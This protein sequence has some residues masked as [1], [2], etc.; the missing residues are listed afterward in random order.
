MDMN[1]EKIH[2]IL[3]EIDNWENVPINRV[4]NNQRFYNNSTELT[5]RIIMFGATQTG[6]TTVIL[7]LMGVKDNRQNEL[8]EI[9]RGGIAYGKSSTSTTVIYSRSRN[10]KFAIAYGDSKNLEIDDSTYQEFD[11]KEFKDKIG[12]Q[13]EANRKNVR[14]DASA[15]RTTYIFIPDEFFKENSSPNLQIVDSRG[16]GERNVRIDDKNYVSSGEINGFVDALM[17]FASG[18]VAVVTVDKIK[19]LSSEYNEILRKKAKGQVL[20][21]VTHSIDRNHSIISETK[22][23][24]MRVMADAIK[25]QYNSIIIDNGY[26][27]SKFSDRIYPIEVKDFMLNDMRFKEYADL[28][29]YMTQ[30]I[31]NEIDKMKCKSSIGI[32][33]DNL[34][35][36]IQELEDKKKRLNSEKDDKDKE[37]ENKT[38]SVDSEKK[39]IKDVNESIKKLENKTKELEQKHSRIMEICKTAERLDNLSDCGFNI[40]YDRNINENIKKLEK[41]VHKGVNEL[42]SD[43]E[44]SY[45]PIVDNAVQ[46]YLSGCNLSNDVRRRLTRDKWRRKVRSKAFEYVIDSVPECVEAI[47][48]A[49]KE[50]KKK[51]NN[52]KELNKLKGEKVSFET[53]IKSKQVAISKLNSEVDKKQAAVDALQKDITRLLYYEQHIE[54]VFVEAYYEKKDELIERMNMEKDPQIINALFIVLATITNNMS[55]MLSKVEE[56]AR[57]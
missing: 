39:H 37:I 38:K 40:D 17:P 6:K 12:E 28:V 19:S 20:V 2:Q 25:A 7:S 35:T 32:C 55:S 29:D 22:S 36:H 45:M 27:D 34:E 46:E 41:C 3:G 1:S 4:L 54:D 18:V 5:K 57:V 9:L 16:F 23:S 26:V 11:V 44:E 10:E 24:D 50:E 47:K 14:P 52:P 13:K 31:I 51:N 42:F 53:A 33:R 30:D 8:G 43:L 15:H 48:K 49:L 56:N 21:V